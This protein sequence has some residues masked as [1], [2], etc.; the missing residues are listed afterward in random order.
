MSSRIFLRPSV[1]VFVCEQRNS[2]SYGRI[3]VEDS[4]G[5]GGHG[6]KN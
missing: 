5:V 4:G 1:C 6:R 2:Q 3:V